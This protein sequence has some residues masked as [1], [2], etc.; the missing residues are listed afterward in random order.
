[1]SVDFKVYQETSKVAEYI[2]IDYINNRVPEK[3][4]SLFP[5]RVALDEVKVEK[6]TDIWG[7]WNALVRTT[8]EDDL[9]FKVVFDSD[10]KTY[11]VDVYRKIDQQVLQKAE[12]FPGE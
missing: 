3:L 10:A 12:L 4:S 8:L 6:L 5:V 7:S 1:L 9:E 2:V 11:C